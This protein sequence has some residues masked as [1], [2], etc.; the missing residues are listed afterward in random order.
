MALVLT[1]SSDLGG[2]ADD[3]YAATGQDAFFN[4]GAAGVQRVFDAGLL[5][6]HGHFGGG[7]HIDLG[8]A[9]GELGQA[10]LELF[11]VVVAGGVVDLVLERGDAALD[12]LLI[13]G[14]FDDGGVVFI[15]ADLLGPTEV[16]QLDV[17]ELETKLFEDGWCHR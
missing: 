17:F 16:G 15:D 8:D 4:G 7:A 3:G 12:G 6:L 10:F 9:A 5:F 11:L 13:S 14:A 2:G 1:A